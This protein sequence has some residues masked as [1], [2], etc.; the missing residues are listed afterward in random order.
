MV[1]GKK[2]AQRTCAGMR[3]LTGL[4][5]HPSLTTRRSG[6]TSWPALGPRQ[7]CDRLV[8]GVQG[9][10]L[11]RTP[12]AWN[13]ERESWSARG[14][15]PD[16]RASRLFIQLSVQR[17][18]PRQPPAKVCSW[19]DVCEPRLRFLRSRP[20]IG[21]KGVAREQP[22]NTTQHTENREDRPVEN[23]GRPAPR[24][25]VPPQFRIPRQRSHVVRDPPRGGFPSASTR[26]GVV[27]GSLPQVAPS[28]VEV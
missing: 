23:H 26:P 12:T 2:A 3:T 16:G 13:T 1:V 28:C 8:V 14:R 19:Y 6:G 27:T 22:F 20:E 9:S 7:G 15:F 4:S 5:N 10:R 21:A 25:E 18:V 24:Q 17:T 11:S